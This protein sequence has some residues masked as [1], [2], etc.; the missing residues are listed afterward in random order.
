MECQKKEKIIIKNSYYHEGTVEEFKFSA[1]VVA[2]I[3]L[4]SSLNPTS[5]LTCQ[6]S[7]E[8]YA[9]VD[10]SENMTDKGNSCS[11][12]AFSPL[13]QFTK[14]ADELSLR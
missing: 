9:G 6:T 2:S 4:H 8:P 11:L 12:K 13:F 14:H 1:T 7:W 3:F 5:L 10:V